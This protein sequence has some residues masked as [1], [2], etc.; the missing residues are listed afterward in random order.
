[1]SVSQGNRTIAVVIVTYNS[2]GDIRSCLE[3]VKSSRCD[4]AVD[5]VVVDNASVD[6]TANIVAN[7]F[8]DVQL[9]RNEQNLY[10]ARANNQGAEAARGDYLLLLNPDVQLSDG[11]LAQLADY[12]ENNAGVAAVAPRLIYPDGKIQRSVRRF[13]TYS[14]L[15]YELTG[16]RRLFPQHPVFGRWRMNLEDVEQAVDVDQPMA[17]CLLIRRAVWD[18]LGGFDEFFP[19]FFNDV[20]LCYRIKKSGKRIVYLPQASAVHRLGGSVRPVMA[21]MVWFSHL[22]FLRF[23]RQHHR[24]SLDVLKYALTAPFVILA[25]AVRSVSWLCRRNPHKKTRSA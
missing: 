4:A 6:E 10:Y 2:A 12:L 25:A 3:A 21:R 14:M 22:G 11:T 9:I 7:S 15:W 13:P 1:M 20:D 8:P 17:S 23:M 24:F 18:S 19:M 16:L 5:V